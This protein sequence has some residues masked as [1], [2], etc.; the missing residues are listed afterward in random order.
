MN[1]PNVSELMNVGKLRYIQ[2]VF[3]SG[4]YRNPDAMIGVFLSMSQRLD[5]VVR[6]TLLKSRLRANPFY[7]YILARTKYYEEVFLDAVRNSV[8]CIV[9]IGCG[10]DTRAYRFA[11]V[12]KHKGITV[13]ECDQPQA[14]HSKHKIAAQHWSTDHIGYVP[15]DLNETGWTD[16]GRL[17]DERCT[18]PVLV[19]MEGVSPY[20]RSASFKAF[21][22]LLSAK[23][24]P[25]SFLAYDFKIKG[26]RDEFGR[27]ASAPET[28]RLSTDR[29]AVAAYHNAIGFQLQHMELST[30]LTRRLLPQAPL[31]FDQDCLLRLSL[32]RPDMPANRS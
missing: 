1:L 30:E 31:L 7:Y 19:M 13:L 18:G 3:E 5:C 25:D 10:S 9:N 27:S 20:I 4:E 15:L 11:D 23:L 26:L 8:T 16:F 6:G 28:F 22:R 29:T 2:A 14:I 12:L 21:L 17:L 32:V 24:H